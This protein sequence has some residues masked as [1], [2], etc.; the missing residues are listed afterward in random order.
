METQAINAMLPVD[1]AASQPGDSSTTPE[2]GNT[3]LQAL[4]GLVSKHKG[5]EDKPDTAQTAAT[6]GAPA[7]EQ[8][9]DTSAMNDLAAMMASLDPAAIQP[10][11]YDHT[12]PLPA[13]DA[14]GESVLGTLNVPATSPSVNPDDIKTES[15]GKDFPV[16]GNTWQ[17]GQ[18]MRDLMAEEQG[19]AA[20][21]GEPANPDKATPAQQAIGPRD[22]SQVMD[23]RSAPQTTLPEIPVRQN[24]RQPAEESSLKSL[25]A[26][27]DLKNADQN[28]H[29][30]TSALASMNQ[31][32]PFHAMAIQS[33]FGSQAGISSLESAAAN[34]IAPRVGS[35]GWSEAMGQKIVMMA[36]E[37]VQQAELK[38]NPEGLGPMQVVLSLEKGAADVQFLA[39][40]P[41]VRDALQ[42][43]LPRLQEMLNSAGFSLDKVSID[44]GS[45]RNQDNPNNQPFQ[46]ARSDKDA[47]DAR[48]GES[49][50][51][52]MP[53]GRVVT[54]ARPGRI[55]TFA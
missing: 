42:S 27:R 23:A 25:S 50:T 22:F 8:A 44:A 12:A 39:H 41:Q 33:G 51:Q 28:S 47:S 2:D 34:L 6:A 54:Q 20:N 11:N 21:A 38:L 9:D 35:S 10:A 46:Q 4:S 32:S 48:L 52:P 30:D 49:D 7:G 36:S 29:K 14:S 40:D 13:A 19:K 18:A 3:F 37:N 26:L 17:S 15:A 1:P 43:A 24:L 55:D 45:A 5:K 53:L 16:A 31:S